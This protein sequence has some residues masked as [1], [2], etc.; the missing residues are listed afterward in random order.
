MIIGSDA[1]HKEQLKFIEYGV[2]QARRGWLEK[3][4]I[5][6]CYPLEKMLKMLKNNKS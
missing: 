6:N 3:K 1:H 5:L 2:S 4:D